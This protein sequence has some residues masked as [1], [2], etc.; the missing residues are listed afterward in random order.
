LVERS[1]SNHVERS[2]AELLLTPER[3]LSKRGLL[4]DRGLA[5]TETAKRRAKPDEAAVIKE[6]ITKSNV[7]NE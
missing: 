5:E 1:K 3:A 7:K 2:S 4:K 6:R